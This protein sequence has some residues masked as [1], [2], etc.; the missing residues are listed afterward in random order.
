MHVLRTYRLSVVGALVGLLLLGAA[1]LAQAGTS[2]CYNPVADTK[3]LIR[4]VEQALVHY[5]TD[6][7]MSCPPTVDMLA[8]EHYLTRAPLDAWGHPFHFQCPGLHAVDGADVSSAG[9]DGVFGTAD[10]LVS[11]E[12]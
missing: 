2:H 1:L 3:V 11:W 7:A 9:R 6:N 8:S 5:Q 4:S 12:L 10:D